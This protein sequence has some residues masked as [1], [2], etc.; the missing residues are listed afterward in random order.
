MADGSII[1]GKNNEK[2][3]VVKASSIGSGSNFN[4]LMNNEVAS[5]PFVT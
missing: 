4:A 3:T 5:F 1:G 2:G